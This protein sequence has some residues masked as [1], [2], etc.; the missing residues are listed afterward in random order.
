MMTQ[1]HNLQSNHFGVRKDSFS[2][3]L[4]K[5]SS[6]ATSSRNM[7]TAKTT[8]AKTFNLPIVKRSSNFQLTQNI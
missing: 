6:G 1:E 8:P 3:A 7:D 4:N 5:L 2:R